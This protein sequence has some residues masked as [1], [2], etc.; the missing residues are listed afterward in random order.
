MGFDQIKVVER[1]PFKLN[2]A[3]RYPLFTPDLIDLME[4]LLSP[5]RQAEVA[6]GVTVTATRPG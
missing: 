1:H 4:K 5:E 6:T 2:D 3:A